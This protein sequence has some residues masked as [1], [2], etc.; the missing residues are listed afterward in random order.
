MTAVIRRPFLS[1]A[2]L[3]CGLAA[4]GG[5]V[6]VRAVDAADKTAAEKPATQTAGTD[7]TGAGPLLAYEARLAGDDARGRLVISFDR[8][9]DYRIHYLA[10]PYRVVIDLPETAFGIK[11]DDLSARGL[12][13][14]IRYGA[15]GS[16][17]ARIVMTATRPV[18]V[19]LSDVRPEEDGRGYRLVVDTAMGTP[20][21]FADR[22]AKQTWNQVGTVKPMEASLPTTPDDG[23]FVIAVDAGHGGID[24]GASGATTNTPEKDVTLAFA[25]ELAGALGKQDGVARGADARQG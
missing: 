10:D 16:G 2:A 3:A 7:T 5:T 9:P 25:R 6:P 12:F 8:K 23:K 13:R 20:A 24:A 22:L 14:D 18:L 17:Q 4:F 15:M 21:D 19:T 1:M 11:P